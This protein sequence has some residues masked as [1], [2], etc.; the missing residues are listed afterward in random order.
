MALRVPGVVVRPRQ[1][2]VRSGYPALTA[3]WARW[4]LDAPAAGTR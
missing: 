4:D 3:G 1:R 2:L